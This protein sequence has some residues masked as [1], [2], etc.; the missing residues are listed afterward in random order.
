MLT[1]NDSGKRPRQGDI[2]AN[3]SRL[4]TNV[5]IHIKVLIEEHG[6]NLESL[7]NAVVETLLTEARDKEFLP[8]N[9]LQ[10]LANLIIKRCTDKDGIISLEYVDSMGRKY[11]YHYVAVR[12]ARKK[13]NTL[14]NN[15]QIKRKAK[16]LYICLDQQN[17]QQVPILTE[18]AKGKGLKLVQQEER[19]LDVKE[20]I[21]LRDF[22]RT[23]QNGV[24]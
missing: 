24:M 16:P 17:D 22:A 1:G 15:R 14:E 3:D 2:K 5:N 18:I 13:A 10:T 23:S 7:V 11:P 9:E 19:V 8:S 4:P 21:A 20:V 12:S 6:V